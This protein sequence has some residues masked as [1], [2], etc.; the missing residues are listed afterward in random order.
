[1]RLLNPNTRREAKFYARRIID[2]TNTMVRCNSNDELNV[3]R[4]K[5]NS[6]LISSNLD[7]ETLSKLVNDWEKDFKNNHQLQTDELDWIKKDKSASLFVFSII[8]SQ[9]TL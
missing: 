1:M 8:S 6:K 2:H 3:I 9:N 5:L 4:K 7:M